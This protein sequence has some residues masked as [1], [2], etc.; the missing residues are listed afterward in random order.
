MQDKDGVSDWQHGPELSL[1]W[2]Y[3][4]GLLLLGKRNYTNAITTPFGPKHWF[5]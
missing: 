1:A 2:E 3:H 5:K 4:S